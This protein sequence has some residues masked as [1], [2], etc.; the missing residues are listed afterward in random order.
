MDH[1]SNTASMKYGV[2][3]ALFERYLGIHDLDCELAILRN[4]EIG[5]VAGVALVV[6]TNRA[7]ALTRR[8]TVF[9]LARI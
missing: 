8:A 6:Q 4:P 5:H 1:K 2:R 7:R 3:F 9:L